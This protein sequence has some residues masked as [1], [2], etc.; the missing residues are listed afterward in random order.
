MV[1]GRAACCGFLASFGETKTGFEI[2]SVAS[3]RKGCISDV[4]SKEGFLLFQNL[5][6]M[7]RAVQ[8]DN[9]IR[10]EGHDWAFL[11]LIQHQLK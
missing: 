8:V 11:R 4:A 7:T 5:P 6:K 9:A 10:L 3:T 1:R 2:G